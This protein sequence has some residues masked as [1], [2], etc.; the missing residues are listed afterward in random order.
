MFRLEHLQACGKRSL[1]GAKQKEN[2]VSLRGKHRGRQ[3]P[4]QSVQWVMILFIVVKT[5]GGYLLHLG[6]SMWE[7]V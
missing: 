3:V 1:L 7:A 5:P 4:K 2:L 6:L